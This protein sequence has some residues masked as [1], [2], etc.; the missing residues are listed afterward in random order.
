M[1]EQYDSREQGKS[2]KNQQGNPQHD[3][4]GVRVRD[5]DGNSSTGKNLPEQNIPVSIEDA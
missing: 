2:T 4:H 3:M 5:S 1:E